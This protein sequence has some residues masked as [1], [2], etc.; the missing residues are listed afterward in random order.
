MLRHHIIAAARR[1][2]RHGSYSL[3]NVFGLAIGLAACFAVGLFIQDEVSYDRFHEKADS[4]YRVG[5]KVGTTGGSAR[6]PAIAGERIASRYPEV[7]NVV[8]LYPAPAVVHVGG[9]AR[10]EEQFYYADPSLFDIFS[11]PLV[12]GDPAAALREPGSL[13]LTQETAR[14]YF[15]GSDPIGQIVHLQG[16]AEFRVTGVV[17]DIPAHSHLQFDFLASFS[18]LGDPEVVPDYER[19]WGRQSLTYFLLATPASAASLQSKLDALT[20]GSLQ[21]VQQ[22]LGF[23]IEGME[24]GL[25]PITKIHL[26]PFLSGAVQPDGDLRYLYVF[27]AVALVILLIS[28]INYM[29]IATA[30]SAWRAREVGVR[31]ALGARRSQLTRQFLV[32]SLLFSTLAFLLALCFIKAALPAF[33]SFTGKALSLRITDNPE[34]FAFFAA[35]AFLAGI[36]GGFYPALVLSRFAPACVLKGT[37]HEAGGVW[38]RRALVTFQFAIA[39]GLIAGTAVMHK[40][41]NYM[42]EEPLGYETEQILVLPLKAT[43]QQR[44]D[45]LSRELLLIPGV[46]RVSFASGTPNDY[47]STSVGYRGQ[48]YKVHYLAVDR[49]YVEAMGMDIIAGRD[50]SVERLGGNDAGV[51]INETAARIFSLDVGRRFDFGMSQGAEVIGIVRDFHASSLRNPIVPTVL[52]L[53]DSYFSKIL[54]RLAPGESRAALDRLQDTW[55]ALVP[56]YPLQYRF[57][58]ETIDGHYRSEE[59]FASVFGSFTLMAIVLACLG[60]FGMAAFVVERRAKEI[61]IRRIL[62]A[63]VAHILALTSREFVIVIT[64]AFLIAAPVSYRLMSLWLEDYAYRVAIGMD[65]LLFAGVL[66]LVIAIATIS[67]QA[68]R[69]AFATPVQFLRDSE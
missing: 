46:E 38:F 35:V 67:V 18:T 43:V 31:K 23:G 56:D 44:A 22:A 29:N 12:R 28:C 4:I 10:E 51:I 66:A 11:F 32:E 53:E 2:R 69:A 1:V 40:Q 27:G 21:E 64:V 55:H 58:D 65:T 34:I 30:R 37:P 42:Q 6:L 36:L 19:A 15:G 8:R 20:S 57:L 25:Q 9:E 7:E 54:I 5:M 39:I 13:V 52:A 3:I 68:L 50:F 60:L 45:A 14:R 33:N 63:T 17:A 26:Y 62:G 41:L 59:R 24:L 61:G 49:E 47:M 48:Q 16:G